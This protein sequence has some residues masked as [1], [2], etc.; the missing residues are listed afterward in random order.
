M[1]L[2]IIIL[3]EVTQRK[4]DTTSLMCGIQKTMQTNLFTKEKQTHSHTE[5]TCGYQEERRRVN[6][7]YGT[8][9]P[10]Y[11]RQMQQDLLYRTGVEAWYPTITYDGKESE[12]EI[13]YLY[14]TC[15]F[16]FVNL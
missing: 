6:Q 11:V 5:Q 2:E 12:K 8:H 1:N 15:T 13:L 4:T 10:L 9:T 7:E 14:M 16:I 3:S